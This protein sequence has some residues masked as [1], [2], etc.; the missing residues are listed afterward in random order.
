[1]EITPIGWLLL[2]LGL[3]LAVARVK[4][5]YCLTLFLL[6]FTATAVINVGS[7]ANASGVQAS[8][9]LGSLLLVRFG[10]GLLLRGLLPLPRS[11]R[12]GLVWLG[13]FLAVIA[14]SLVMPVWINGQVQV[15]SPSLLDR[16]SHPLYLKSSN[17]TGV[18]FIVFGFAYAFLI[19]AWNRQPDML[20][21]TMKT[22]LAGSAFSAVWALLELACK[23]SGIPYPAFVFNTS[24]SP[25]AGGYREV[26]EGGVFRLSSVSVEPSIFAQFLLI[27]LALY[28]PFVL[29][30]HRV[31]GKALDRALFALMFVVLFLT[32]S[33]TAYIGALAGILLVLF[34]LT[35][36][37]VLRPKHIVAPLAGLAVIGLIYATVPVAQQVV[38]SVLLSKGGGYSA[39]ERLMTISNSYR[40]FLQYP[41]LGIGWAS[42]ASHDL[43][44]NIIANCGVLGLAAFAIA[45][46]FTFRTLYRSIRSRSAT[47]A[48]LMQLDMALFVALAVTVI[49]CIISGAL[50]VFPFFWFLCG[51]AIVMPDLMASG[52]ASRAF[53]ANRYRQNSVH[54]S[55]AARIRM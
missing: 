6:P 19:T 22:F 27:A 45:M 11:G 35:I 43:I 8:M 18:L 32:T 5:L 7:G 33:S 2:P 9:Y 28:L 54:V 38:E 25:S 51:L 24:A 13:I 52:A 26:L 37:G 4:W 49:T 10:V 44:V 3:L 16:S 21:L 40:M 47:F 48:A 39:L 34:L 55:Q 31:F 30:A 12:S 41:L 15:P 14:I 23:V 42:I 1:M 53:A 29:G 46:F 20:R 17:I 36:R 50:F